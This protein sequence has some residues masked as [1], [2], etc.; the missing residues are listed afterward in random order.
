MLGK[1]SNIQF[2]VT[3]S[4]SSP[5]ACSTIPID[6]L[7]TRDPSRASL[8][9]RLDTPAPAAPPPLV[10]RQLRQLPPLVLGLIPLLLLPLLLV[11]L[12]VLVLVLLVLLLQAARRH[13]V[14][15]SLQETCFHHHQHRKNHQHHQHHKNQQHLHKPASLG[16]SFCGGG[17]PSFL[18]LPL[19][20][21]LPLLPGAIKSALHFLRAARSQLF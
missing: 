17:L 4:C 3:V 5:W 8:F 16:V 1:T 13:A 20:P 12:L 6:R 11:V 19:P 21:F 10:L 2:I 15:D 18:P 7:A 9:P 14:C